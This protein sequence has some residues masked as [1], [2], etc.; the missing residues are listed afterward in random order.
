MLGGQPLLQGLPEPLDLA[1]GLRVIGLAV[2]LPDPQAAQL[3]FEAVAAAAAAGETRRV[4]QAVIGQ[5]RGRGAVGGDGGAEG[6]HHDG[7][8]HALVAGQA[9][10]QPG[11]VVQPGQDLGIGA[12]PAAGPGQPV[13]GEVRLPAL[14]RQVGGEPQVGVPV[15]DCLCPD[16]TARRANQKG[17]ARAYPGLIWQIVARQGG[18]D[19]VMPESAVGYG[20]AISI[21][22]S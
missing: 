21:A 11:M 5:R 4:D 10:Y 2:L 17:Q 18:P 16:W 19:T 8:G 22:L 13:V 12:G 1:L 14:V 6:I 9:Q 3:V 20:P 7:A 15:G